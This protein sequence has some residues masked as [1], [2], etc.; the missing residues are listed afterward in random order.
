MTEPNPYNKDKS[1]LDVK[2]LERLDAKT[3]DQSVDNSAEVQN[4]EFCKLNNERTLIVTLG[5]NK[6]GLKWA[7]LLRLLLSIFR[8][9]LSQIFKALLNK[10]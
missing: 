8:R 5:G 3:N 1:S 2:W 10:T 6:L 7:N 4:C 9:Y